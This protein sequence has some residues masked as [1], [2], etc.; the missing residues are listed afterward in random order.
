[1][2]GPNSRRVRQTNLEAGGM[3]ALE[4][5]DALVGHTG[6]RQRSSGRK[7]VPQTLPLIGAVDETG[8]AD[9][10]VLPETLTA[11]EDRLAYK[12]GE[13]AGLA[14]KVQDLRR[15]LDEQNRLLG[16]K[17]VEITQLRED[18]AALRKHDCTVGSD[19]FASLKSLA[20]LLLFPEGY[21]KKR[22]QEIKSLILNARA[23]DAMSKGMIAEAANLI[24]ESQRE[25]M[26][27]VLP[28]ARNLLDV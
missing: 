13:S 24:M 6:R 21:S 7:R 10:T 15:M 23:S 20:L 2:P 5:G 18:I 11:A 1:M 12:E 9:P 16:S 19:R 26:L 17:D 3:T 4:L 25:D 14:D 8:T 22:I 27:E 28:E